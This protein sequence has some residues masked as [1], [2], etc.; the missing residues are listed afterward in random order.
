M[1]DLIPA[2]VDLINRIQIYNSMINDD[3]V[4]LGD[5]DKTI[6]K[7]EKGQEPRLLLSYND[8]DKYPFAIDFSFAGIEAERYSNYSMVEEDPRRL[9]VRDIQ[10]FDVE[11][12]RGA[13]ENDIHH[14]LPHRFAFANDKIFGK[15]RWETFVATC[16]RG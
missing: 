2:D 1:V 13:S 8:E 11:N 4:Y 16:S 6:R 7:L 9:F 15:G 5:N 10:K 3:F 12:L 14:I